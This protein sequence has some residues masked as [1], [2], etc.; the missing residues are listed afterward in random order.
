M[1]RWKSSNSLKKYLNI[2]NFH[3]DG[4]SILNENYT[5]ENDDGINLKPFEKFASS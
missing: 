4:F 5:E 3:L 1:Q 2:L